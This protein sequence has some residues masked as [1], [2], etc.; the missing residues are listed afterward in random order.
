MR[1][2]SCGMT[3]H[4]VCVHNRELTCSVAIGGTLDE[5]PVVACDTDDRRPMLQ[6]YSALERVVALSLSGT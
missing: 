5:R 4:L 2:A 1:G 3:V 6:I